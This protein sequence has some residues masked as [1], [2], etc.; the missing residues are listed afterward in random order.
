MATDTH[1]EESMSMFLAGLSGVVAGS[2]H[3]VSGPDHLAA[4]LPLAVEGR[5][6][7]AATGAWWGVGHAVGVVV[8]GVVGH[9]L[10][11]Q[12]D[13]QF[14][15]EISEFAVGLLLVALGAWTIR[16]AGIPAQERAPHTHRSALG[17]GF[18]HGTAGAGHLFGVLPTLGMD[19][20][21]AVAYLIAYMAAAVG[22]MAIFALLVGAV[23]RKPTHIPWAMRGAGLAAVVVGCAWVW[24]AV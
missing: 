7:A 1:T 18:L 2:T 12:L 23:A 5:W 21:A 22:S 10:A 4:V 19:S 6:R 14:L 16:R 24:M 9:L 15:S 20:G 3:V 17:I 11:D 13:I 8:L